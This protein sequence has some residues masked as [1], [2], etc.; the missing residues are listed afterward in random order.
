MMASLLAGLV[1]LLCGC[2]PRWTG[3]VD[4]DA[5]CVF[6]ANHASHFDAVLIWSALPPAARQRC[7]MVAA[8]DYWQATRLRRW[9]ATSIFHAILI[10][11]LKPSRANNPID[12]ICQALQAGQSV[13]IFPEG[14]RSDDDELQVFRN[15]LWHIARRRPEQMF[16]PVW[17]ENLSRVLPK[18]EFLPVPIICGLTF[19]TPCIRTDGQDR[20]AFMQC[21]RDRLAQLGKGST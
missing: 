1:R 6:Y 9:L 5:P 16:V 12:Q 13:I 14:T 10:D 4:L 7:H 19:G 20:D 3:P 2:R 18:G 8:A 17:L 11:R 21:L 15:G